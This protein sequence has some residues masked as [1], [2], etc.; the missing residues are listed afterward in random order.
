MGQGESI[1]DKLDDNLFNIELGMKKLEKIKKQTLKEHSKCM[2]KA[3]KAIRENDV[4]TA[5]IHT[6]S[7]TAHHNAYLKLDESMN[8][9]RQL[10]THVQTN[11]HMGS[12]SKEIF[13][14][15]Q[16][17]A[18][19]MSSIDLKNNTTDMDKL[20]EDM[21]VDLSKFTDVVNAKIPKVDVETTQ[22][23]EL[24][25]KLMVEENLNHEISVYENHAR[26]GVSL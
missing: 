18:K 9:M 11:V 13:E 10:I 19:F 12:I 2:N 1:E 4:T 8:K 23:D 25:E 21:N 3:R 17:S 16:T 26:E 20:L 15:T 7:A 22:S 5:Q 6:N 14:C 24:L